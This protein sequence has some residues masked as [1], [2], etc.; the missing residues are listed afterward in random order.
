MWSST[1][2]LSRK[3]A[4]FFRLSFNFSQ[5]KKFRMNSNFLSII[6]SKMAHVVANVWFL[7][8]SHFGSIVSVWPGKSDSKSTMKSA[9]I[10]S[11]VLTMKFTLRFFFCC[12]LTY[13]EPFAMINDLAWL[14]FTKRTYDEIRF[15]SI[16]FLF[17]SFSF[18]F[19]LFFSLKK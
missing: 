8:F 15:I 3:F 1:A 13:S 5:I 2:T 4:S 17:L 14:N 10:F 19:L 9:S 6:N 18:R 7:F 16:L 11:V 12:A